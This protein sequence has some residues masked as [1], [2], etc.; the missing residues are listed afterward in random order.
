MEHVS[1]RTP[2][3]DRSQESG[4][5]TLGWTAFLVIVVVAVAALF[6]GAIHRRLAPLPPGVQPSLAGAPSP[7]PSPLPRPGPAPPGT[8]LASL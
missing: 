4:R 3:T 5:G 2:D 1:S 8:T 7:S 6:A